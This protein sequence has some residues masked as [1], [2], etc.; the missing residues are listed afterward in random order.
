MTALQLASTANK[1]PRSKQQTP[2]QV[3]SRGACDLVWLHTSAVYI[4]TRSAPGVWRQEW[5][6]KAFNTGAG[7]EFGH[8]VALSGDLL[9]VSARQESSRAVGV[10]GD[11]L[12]NS[13]GRAGAV[14]QY[15]LSAGNWSRVRYVK[16]LTTGAG[17]EFGS[18]LAL[19]DDGS[20]VVG[21]KSDNSAGRGINPALNELAT[22]AGVALMYRF[23]PPSK[24]ST[25]RPIVAA[26]AT[27]DA[28]SSRRAS[29][30]GDSKNSGFI[31]G[32]VILA[33]TPLIVGAIVFGCVCASRRRKL[34]RAAN[35]DLLPVSSLRPTL[36]IVLLWV[37]ILAC[38]L[39]G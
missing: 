17:D 33:L 38:S 25:L 1:I 31:A 24:V 37:V 13:A 21:S 36:W 28:A 18:S 8:Q 29:I 14:Y 9:A 10:D 39:A 23:A 12:D 32:V 15:R 20:M 27:R 3:R 4:F 5:Y 19:L 6:I 11:E 35:P 26:A 22:N 16:S 2:V 34:M 30:D 7:D